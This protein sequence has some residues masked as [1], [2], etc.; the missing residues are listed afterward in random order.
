LALI[1]KIWEFWKR[2]WWAW[3]LVFC[4]NICGAAIVLVPSL[5]FGNDTPAFILSCIALWFIVGAPAWG[6]IFEKFAAG[7]ARLTDTA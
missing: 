7:S 3:L 4:L 1:S 6:W 5:F 2:G